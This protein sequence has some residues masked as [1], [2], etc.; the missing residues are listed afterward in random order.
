MIENE[1]SYM[2]GASEL[3]ESAANA[4]DVEF[5]RERTEEVFL[6]YSL[7]L[8]ELQTSQAYEI[9]KRLLDIC[10]AIVGLV[11]LGLLL[12]LIVFFIFLEDGGPIFYRH[13]R[14][15][16]YSQSF[17]TYKLRSMIVGADDYL[18]MHPE[19]LQ[20]WQKNGKLEK[21][22]RVTRVGNILRSTSI[23]ELPQMLNVLRGEMSL[24]GPR[25]IQLS[26]VSHFGELIELRQTVK[27]GVTGLWQVSGRSMTSYEQRCVLDCI[28]VMNRSFWMDLRILFKTILIVI[29]GKGAY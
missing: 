1:N 22:P 25:A 28:Y 24:V 12:P 19:L 5:V 26:E 17:V 10:G 11:L 27:P 21:D 14:I 23:D 3:G 2:S 18:R 4:I 15:G 6:D 29:L 16:R 9:A 13:V 20:V 7:R 8:D